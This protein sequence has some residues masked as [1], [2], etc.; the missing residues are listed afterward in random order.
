MIIGLIILLAGVASLVF[1]ILGMRKVHLFAQS[2]Y[3]SAWFENAEYVD[4]KKVKGW[5]IFFAVCEGISA[6]SSLAS[7]IFSAASEGCLCAVIILA[8]MLVNKYFLAEQN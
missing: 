4:I 6:L 3:K 2:I 7:N 5:L 8:I 1:N